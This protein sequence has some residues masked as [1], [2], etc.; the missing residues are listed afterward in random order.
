MNIFSRKGTVSPKYSNKELPFYLLLSL[1]LLNACSSRIANELSDIK[2]EK[3]GSYIQ[4]R[5]EMAEACKGFFVNEDT[6]K[7][8][9][10][11]A[12]IT[13]S[14]KAINNSEKLPCYASGTT[15]IGDETYQWVLRS[16]GIGMFYNAENKITKICGVRCCDKVKGVC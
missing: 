15:Y 8:F 13:N 5:P 7:G 10:T 9:Y 3:Q 12:S 16:G 14:E 6:L 2:T 11:N 1:L 4:E